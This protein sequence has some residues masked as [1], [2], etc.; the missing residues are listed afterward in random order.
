[1]P[2]FLSHVTVKIQRLCSVYIVYGAKGL[3]LNRTQIWQ[4]FGRNRWS[5]F[6]NIEVISLSY[7]PSNFINL[8]VVKFSIRVFHKL[9]I[10]EPL[11]SWKLQFLEIFIITQKFASS[12]GNRERNGKSVFYTEENFWGAYLLAK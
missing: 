4:I 8:P 2:L 9:L 7:F 3:P 6:Q 10:T 5:L 1:M 12:N 11:A